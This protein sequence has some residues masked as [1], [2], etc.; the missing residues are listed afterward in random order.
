M[1]SC[2]MQHQV[3]HPVAIPSYIDSNCAYVVTKITI[4]TTTKAAYEGLPTHI[5]SEP[6][7]NNVSVAPTF[8][9]ASISFV[10]IA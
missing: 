7:I 4:V 5:I 8:T 3:V 2:W 6:Y 9:N 10:V 1:S